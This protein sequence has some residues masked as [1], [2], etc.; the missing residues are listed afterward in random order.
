[1]RR[2][3]DIK[4]LLIVL[5]SFFVLPSNATVSSDQRLFSLVPP[6]AQVVAGMIATRR[7]DQPK[8]FII[9]THHNWLDLQDFFALTGADSSRT[10][11]EVILVAV[12]DNRERLSEHSLLAGGHFDQAHIFRSAVDGG[13]QVTHYR[14][15][16]VLSIEPFARERGDLHDVRWLAILDSDILLFGTIANVQQ[17]LDRHLAGNI[18]DRSIVQRLNRLRREDETWC[19]LAAPVHSDEIGNILARLD[20]ALA[21]LVENGGAFQFG[22]HYNGHVEFEYEVTATSEIDPE[23][24]TNSWTASLIDRKASLLPPRSDKAEGNYTVRGTVKVSKQR[25][26]AWL[27]EI[28]STR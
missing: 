6:G 13:A 11:H 14:S 4:P 10:I 28:S 3:L 27:A 21:G 8:N 7:P 26:D 19:L 24:I 22:I 20:P 12:A 16:P 18:A 5:I 15:I 2:F 9:V 17:E 1:M 23:V 25:Y